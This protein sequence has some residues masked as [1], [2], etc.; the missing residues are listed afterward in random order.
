M[1]QQG[2]KVFM[3][4]KLKS[5]YNLPNKKKWDINDF[6]MH[7]RDNNITTKVEWYKYFTN[8]ILDGLSL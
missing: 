8:D 3:W 5:D 1:L 4:D 6:M 7:L 2:Q